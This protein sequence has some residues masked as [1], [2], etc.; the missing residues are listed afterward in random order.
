MPLYQSDVLKNTRDTHS[1]YLKTWEGRLIGSCK[2]NLIKLATSAKSLSN[3]KVQIATIML[4]VQ[5]IFCVSMQWNDQE[6]FHLQSPKSQRCL[7]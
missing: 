7:L 5:Y 2:V 4:I 1:K 6:I 3:S